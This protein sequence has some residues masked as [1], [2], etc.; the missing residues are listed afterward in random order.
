MPEEINAAQQGVAMEYVYVSPYNYVWQHRYAWYWR[1][2]DHILYEMGIEANHMVMPVDGWAL[3]DDIAESVNVYMD[4]RV[5]PE[6]AKHYVDLAIGVHHGQGRVLFNPFTLSSADYETR[7]ANAL[8][9][10]MA[11]FSH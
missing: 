11:M 6:E 3:I 5:A 8:F 4:A 9:F 2:F 10:D 1:S 7:M